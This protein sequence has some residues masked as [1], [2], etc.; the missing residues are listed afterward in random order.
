M[1]ISRRSRQ[2]LPRTNCECCGRTMPKRGGI[3]CR[4]CGTI[5]GFITERG[6]RE[7]T[8]VSRA[9]QIAI[10]QMATKLKIMASRIDFRHSSKG[11]PNPE[12]EQLRVLF[13][14]NQIQVTEAGGSVI[15]F[16]VKSQDHLFTTW[17]N[18]TDRGFRI[19]D[20]SG[21]ELLEVR[22]TR[23]NLTGTGVAR[24]RTMIVVG[25]TPFASLNLP[26]S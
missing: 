17:A 24:V 3:Q 26:I 2:I 19:C 1:T 25:D 13:R 15:T 14:E 10:V 8:E 7:H 11:C 4:H 22:L 16:V 23:G 12:I 9:A 5:N 18:S 6:G 21:R 20:P